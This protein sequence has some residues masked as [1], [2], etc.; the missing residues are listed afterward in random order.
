[1]RRRKKLLVFG[2]IVIVLVLGF[3]I[4][5]S[6]DNEYRLQ[7]NTAEAIEIGRIYS[8]G[9]FA[10]AEQPGMRILWS[11][12]PAP[13]KLKNYDFKQA[14]SLSSIFEH[15][16]KNKGRLY[17]LWSAEREE[18]ELVALERLGSTLVMT[19]AYMPFNEK[20]IAEIPG[21]GKI[22]FAIAAHYFDPEEDKL[23]F[24][25]TDKLLRKIANL[26]ILQ[27]FTGYSK[28]KGIWKVFDFKYTY[29]RND[30]Y[31]WILKEGENYHIHDVQNAN[32]EW[33]EWRKKPIREFMEYV[34]R[35]A[36]EMVDFSYTWANQTMD[37]QIKNIQEIDKEYKKV[38]DSK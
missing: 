27:E 4:Y 29:N 23:F 9:L 30:Y 19:F 6:P 8:F 5:R 14:Q 3:L 10:N 1:M 24:K 25:Y 20:K 36:E 12:E 33:E 38:F 11:I 18:M 7:E 16:E 22:L 35:T 34:N 31:N 15:G 21:K 37:S 17:S 28:A 32:K 2:I 13:I 26:P